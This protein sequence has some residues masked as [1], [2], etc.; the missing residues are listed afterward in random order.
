MK[1]YPAITV[2][3]LGIEID[4][5]IKAGNGDKKILITCDDEGNGYHGLF[6]TFNADI[7][8]IK[9]AQNGGLF[10]DDV[11]LEEVILLG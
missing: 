11:N 10:H 2:A 4:K 1:D 5:Q 8:Q 6:Y 7:G 9:D 3:Q